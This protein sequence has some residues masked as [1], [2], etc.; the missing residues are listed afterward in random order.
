MTTSARA[1]VLR[2]IKGPVTI[3]E[4]EVDDPADN[5]VLVR[6]AACG[7]CHSDL[8]FLQGSIAGPVPTVMG[9][10]PAGV[11]EAVGAAVRGVQPG[12]HV[13]ACTSM[14]C[15]HCKQCL[16]GRPHLCTNRSA[17][18]RP[19]GGR[20]R[21]SQGGDG[22]AQFA[23]LAGF[24]EAMLLHENAVVR[25]DDDIPLDRAALVGCG[26]T[27]GM[28]A[29]LNTARVAPGSAV[30]VFGCGGVGVSVIQGARIA[31]A[32]QIIA[33]DVLPAKLDGARRFGA[34]DTVLSGEEDPVRAIKKL[35]NGGVD[36]AF[37]AVG[38][39]ALTA[40]CFYSLAPRGVAVVVGAIP[41][42]QKLE[43]EPGH[44]YVEKTITGSIMGSNRF[45]IDAPYYL[46]LYRQHRLD[47]DG[48]VSARLPLDG[49]DEAFAKMEA[50]EVTRSVIMFEGA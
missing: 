1:A 45:Q 26:V 8:H 40:Q 28:G 27:T 29:A 30:A 50:G 14:Y 6:T 16:L 38:M 19:R 39:P 46:D 20:P 3:E 24:A 23:D 44:F 49:L 33:V 25:I 2:E 35:S 13:I 7:V 47:L 9:H 41:S 21:L 12:D 15:G 42:G 18:R 11:V 17:V 5:E 36:Y 48:M 34:T 37:D 10:E 4:I 31:G 43:L 22:L 32:R